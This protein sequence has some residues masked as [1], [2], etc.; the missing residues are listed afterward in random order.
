MKPCLRRCRFAL[1][2]PLLFLLAALPTQAAEAPFDPAAYPAEDPRFFGLGWEDLIADFLQLHGLNGNRV[3]LFYYNTVTGETLDWNG[4]E[5][6]TAASTY[7]VPINLVFADKVSRGEMTL[8]DAIGG[9]PLRNIQFN[10]LRNSDNSQGE[11]LIDQLGPYA[12]YKAAMTPYL[13]PSGEELDP[14]HLFENAFTPRQMAFALRLL[15]GEPER[16]PQVLDHM[17]LAQPDSYFRQKE[18]RF[19]IAHKYGYYA[20]PGFRACNDIGIVWTHEPIVLVMMTD[21]VNGGVEALAD[22]CAL[23]CDYSEYWHARHLEEEARREAEALAAAEAEAQARQ[24]EEARARAEALA[25]REA[26]E[27]AKAQQEAEARRLAAEAVSAR[28]DLLNQKRLHYAAIAALLGLMTAAL[29][30][31]RRPARYLA[32]AVLA[33]ALLG[34][35]WSAYRTLW[36]AKAAEAEPVQTEETAAPTPEPT[37]EPAPDPSPTPEPVYELTLGPEDA[38]LLSGLAEAHPELRHVNGTAIEDWALLAQL[39]RELP[40]C[41]VAYTVPLGTL[42]VSSRETELRLEAGCGVTAEEL[43]EKLDVLPRLRRLDITALDL[44]NAATTPIADRYPELDLVWLVRFGRRW[45]VRSDIS[46]F[47]TLQTWPPAYRYTDA[48][49]APLLRYCRHLVALDLGHNA[50]RDLSPLAGLTELKVLILGDNGQIADLSPLANLTRLEY[51]ELFMADRIQDFTPLSHLTE[52]VD[53]CVGYCSGLRDISFVEQMPRLKM[54]WFPGDPI[55][56]GQREAARAARPETTFLFFPSLVSS[57]S[58]GWR[59]T[60]RNVEIRRAFSNWEL[61]LAFRSW[62]DVD[63]APGA[64]LVPVWPLKN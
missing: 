36:Q 54:G 2:F 7:K 14:A 34:V 45:T 12:Q 49:L 50:L 21:A 8:D 6:F 20:D 1:L 29:L 63:Y 19:P 51:M 25:K 15:Y 16:F 60:E 9:V 47:S 52:M 33:L 3:G 17:K 24:A 40:D 37:A 39:Q 42:S 4:D 55:T 61:V 22:Y 46:C 56:D 64:A 43:L 11:L 5:Y 23:M 31:E 35:L 48:D 18:R 30:W 27:R 41:D 13:C 53:L 38:G 32:A 26:E 28:R 10:T 58:D 57:T 59:M 62:D 44:G